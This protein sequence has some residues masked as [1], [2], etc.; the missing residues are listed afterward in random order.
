MAKFTAD[1]VRLERWVRGSFFIADTPTARANKAMMERHFL[2]EWNSDIEATMATIHPDAP[3]QR[4]PA[5]GVDVNGHEAVRSYY[6]SR[7][8][9]WPGPAMKYFDR[10]IVTDDCIHVEGTLAVEPRGS[11]GQAK[12]TANLLSA[13]AVIVVD[14]RDELILGETVYVDGQTLKSNPNG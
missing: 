7:F 12:T 2:V 9:N 6:L 13:P 11:F 5:F 1:D 10:V 4:I 14:F 3:W 8:D